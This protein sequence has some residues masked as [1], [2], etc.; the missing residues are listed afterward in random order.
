MVT[1]NHT[2]PEYWL[3]LQ[4]AMLCAWSDLFNQVW[5]ILKYIHYFVFVNAKWMCIN[6]CE[7]Y[8]SNFHLKDFYFLLTE[9]D[10]S[11]LQP[12][13]WKIMHRNPIAFNDYY[14]VS[15]YIKIKNIRLFP[16]FSFIFLSSSYD[17]I[18]MLFQF[19]LE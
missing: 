13:S 3:L 18:F 5:K 8:D 15:I 10:F 7:C 14:R 1:L 19:S 6:A 4:S 12:G 17:T 11:F 16:K 2:N 9:L